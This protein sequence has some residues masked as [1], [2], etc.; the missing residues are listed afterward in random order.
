MKALTIIALAF[1]HDDGLITVQTQDGNFYALFPPGCVESMNE[2][3]NGRDEIL[4][5]VAVFKEPQVIFGDE[6]GN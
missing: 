2:I 4:M 6:H 3:R 5:T 1:E